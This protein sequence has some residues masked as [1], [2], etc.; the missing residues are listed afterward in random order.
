M[1]LPRVLAKLEAECHADAIFCLQEVSRTWAG[2]RFYHSHA[3]ALLLRALHCTALLSPCPTL[4]A[5]AGD[6]LDTEGGR[7]GHRHW[8]HGAACAPL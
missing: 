8:A 5:L 1:R 2:K 3:E 7:A 4:S 6:S